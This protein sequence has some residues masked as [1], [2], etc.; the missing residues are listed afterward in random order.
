MITQARDPLVS[1]KT[2][3]YLFVEDVDGIYDNAILHG[4]TDCFPPADMDYHDRQAGVIDPEGNYW[5]ISKR[6]VKEAY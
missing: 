4:A 3:F 1:M 6:L 2:A 5:W